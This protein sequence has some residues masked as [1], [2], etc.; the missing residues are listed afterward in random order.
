[1]IVDEASMVTA[2]L[3]YE[4]IQRFDFPFN[5]TLVGDPNQLPP[6]GWG[7]PFLTMY[8]FQDYTHV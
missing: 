2:E 8:R 4:F 7:V 6:I 1:L 3:F 5:I